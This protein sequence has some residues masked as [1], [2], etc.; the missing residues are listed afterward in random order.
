MVS[1][2]LHFSLFLARL[3]VPSKAVRVPCRGFSKKNRETQVTVP[4]RGSRRRGALPP[5]TRYSWPHS[6][7]SFHT[8]SGPSGRS[9]R[10]KPP[11]KVSTSTIV[12]LSVTSPQV[13]GQVYSVG[14]P[15]ARRARGQAPAFPRALRST[16]RATVKEAEGRAGD[17]RDTGIM[18]RPASTAVS[19]RIGSGLGS[20]LPTAASESVT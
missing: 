2:V 5:S 19:R 16:A 4:A 12:T 6:S 14:P 8:P 20:L 3:P 15:G 9:S 7:S 11:N 17:G 10:H 18:M 13:T 1:E